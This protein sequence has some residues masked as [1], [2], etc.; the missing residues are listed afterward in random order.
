MINLTILHFL[1]TIN[2]YH[3]S[4]STID[5]RKSRSLLH[6]EYVLYSQSLHSFFRGTSKHYIGSLAPFYNSVC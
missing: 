3:S 1:K 5:S 4:I 6:V 2:F